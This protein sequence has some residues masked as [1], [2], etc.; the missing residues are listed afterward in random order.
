MQTKNKNQFNPIKNI[1]VKSRIMKAILLAAGEGK[2]LWPLTETVP[3]VMLPICTKPLIIR[4]IEALKENGISEFGVVVKYKEETIREYLQKFAQKEK[5]K[6]TFFTQGEK[7][8]TAAAILS[9]REFF[10][11]ETLVLAA[12]GLIDKKTVEEFLKKIKGKKGI[13]AALKKVGNPQKYGVAVLENGVIRE[14]E[15]KPQKPKS[16]LANISIYKFSN[17]DLDKMEKV[18]KSVRGDYEITDI[19]SGAN[20]IEINGYWKDIGYPWDLIDANKDFLKGIKGRKGEIK[21]STVDGKIVM[22]KD[23]RIVNSYIEGD[24]YIGSGSIIGPNA[25]I[26]GP[27]VIGN[28]CK[29]GPGSSVKESVLFDNVNAKHLTYI[30][31]SV[32]GNN[33]NFGAGAQIANYR[34]DSKEVNVLCGKGN[35]VNSGRKKLGAIIADNVKFGVLASVMPGKMIGANSLIHTNVIVNQ[36]IPSDS[37]VFVKQEIVIS[38]KEKRD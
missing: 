3:K 32:I 15:E 34:F 9:A 23:A 14:M 25:Y 10:E 31:D 38:K 18:K 36:N 35:L 24:V 22:E 6:I 33:V 27:C 30:G 2:R 28:N 16:E 8:G 12:D 13:C 4:V 11:K 7:N 26:R 37:D 19:L 20:G 17:E 5:L 21:S 29:I 1:Y